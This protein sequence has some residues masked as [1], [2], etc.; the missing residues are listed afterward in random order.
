[1]ALVESHLLTILLWLFFW[2]VG[3]ENYFPKVD[4]NLNP[5]NL[6]LPRSWDYRCNQWC[7]A[8]SGDF[9]YHTVPSG[10]DDKSNLVPRRVVPCITW[11]EVQWWICLCIL[12]HWT[13][14]T[15]GDCIYMSDFEVINISI[16]FVF[17][18]WLHV[19]MIKFQMLGEKSVSPVSFHFLNVAIRKILITYEILIGSIY[20]WHQIQ[21]V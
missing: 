3:L 16:S 20:I 11:V 21:K 8:A 18:F 19:E 12:Y 17:L 14:H 6:S 10:K 5:P 13:L 1:M 2:R 9:A 15:E 4:S 7:L